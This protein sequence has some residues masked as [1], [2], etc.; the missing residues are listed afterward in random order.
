MKLLNK[1]ISTTIAMAL[2]IGNATLFSMTTNAAAVNW[3]KVVEN[4]P[5]WIPR[6]FGSAMYF[7]NNYGTTTVDGDLICIV[8]HVPDSC[9][10]SAEINSFKRDDD[11][12]ANSEYEYNMYSFDLDFSS[13]T[14]G[15]NNAVSSPG[16]H[17]E[18]L[19]I[20]NNCAK[21]FDVDI[22][23]EDTETGNTSDIVRYTFVNEE[24]NLKETDIYS[25]LPDSV[26]EFEEYIEQ[27]GNLSFRDGMMIYCN[28]INYSTG[29]SLDV[30]QTGA[31][32]LSL[33]IDESISRD[34]ILSLDGAAD[35]VLKVFKGESEGDVDITFTSGRLWE[36]YAED[37][38]TTTTSIKVDKDLNIIENVK[39]MP[40]WIPQDLDSAVKFSN[41]HGVSFVTDGIICFV[42]PINTDRLDEYSVSFEGSVSKEIASYEL[43]NKVYKNTEKYSPAFNVRAYDIPNDS[44]LTVNFRYGRFESNTR[45]FNS[46]K[47][48]K[49][50]KGYITQTDK[51]SWLPD[52]HEEY[53]AYF[54]KHGT[55]SVQAGYV[56]YCTNVTDT[57]SPYY[58]IEQNGSGVFIEDHEEIS[59]KYDTN[60]ISSDDTDNSKHMIKLFKPV[61]PGTVKLIISKKTYLDNETTYEEDIAYFTITESMDIIPA[62][63]NDLKTNVKG[64]CNGDGIFGISDL[65]FMKKW[66]TGKGNL[67]EYDIADVNSDGNIDI[68]DFVEM[69]KLLINEIK[70]EPRPVMVFIDENYAW[71]AFQVVTVI[72][73]YG[74]AYSFSYND[75]LRS[76]SATQK[77]L[78][79]MNS[80]NWY[81][82]LLNIMETDNRSVDY[83]P[84]RA[85]AEINKFAL[86]AENYVKSELNGIGYMFDAGSRSV[87]IIGNDAE[88]NPV[89]SKIATYGDFVGWI[90][91]L[92]AKDF[93]RLLDTYNIY[94]SEIIDLLEYNRGII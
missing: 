89:N 45:T 61:N 90:D 23:L 88:C 20:L 16:F 50:S 75:D 73:Q 28:S 25:W 69:R 71:T 60:K 76:N 30:E 51:Y 68:F 7:H 87:Y 15:R 21:G 6:D 12:I 56:M 93:I 38:K 72:D 27:N 37:I 39:D 9:K 81:D 58:L 14:S 11:M 49:D 40:E 2:S 77:D 94:G 4:G 65:V 55:F 63:I 66:L 59:M 18:T 36:S 33:A 46:Y 78:V 41:E 79:S 82:K 74:S 53:N 5:S 8:Y 17:Y 92:D 24:G 19:L 44:D 29:A 80:D 70:E 22:S 32:K 86:N 31:G 54:E 34:N 3:D 62:E 52:C 85:M 48:K 26:P 64:D 13:N 84:D 47:F 57:D 42:Y 67:A 35:N 10:M 1:I 83:I 91:D 43:T